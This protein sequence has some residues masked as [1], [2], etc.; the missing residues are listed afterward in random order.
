[1]PG[2]ITHVLMAEKTINELSDNIVTKAINKH[3][4]LFILGV[5]GPDFLYYHSSL[6]GS[7]SR[8]RKHFTQLGNDI[9]SEHVNDFYHLAIMIVKNEKDSVK[10][11]K[12]I[13]Y[14]A[15]HLSHW[16]L[17]SQTHPFIFY[18][19]NGTTPETKYDHYRYEAMIDNYMFHD[20]KDEVTLNLPVANLISKTNDI[21]V[22]TAIYQPICNELWHV[23]VDLRHIVK[24]FRDF[25]NVLLLSYDPIGVWHQ[26]IAFFELIIKDKWRYT[27]HFITLKKDLTKD[28]LNINRQKWNDPCDCSKVYH[29]SFLELFYQSIDLNTRV[30]TELNNVFIHDTD[31]ELLTI[32]NDRSY[33]TGHNDHQTMKY[34]DPIY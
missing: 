3:H 7:D 28:I 25:H 19:T 12:M 34:F 33:D 1:M 9:H 17:D 20:Q 10:K 21:D 4:D 23:S 32:I 8:L 18:R 5:S 31:K 30:L 14:L 26:I 6:P 2:L 13:A 22:I 29:D 16:A 11:E 24:A 15:G 27:S